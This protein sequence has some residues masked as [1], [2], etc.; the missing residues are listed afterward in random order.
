MSAP[1]L[2][3]PAEYHSTF[4][5]LHGKMLDYR[6]T[7]PFCYVTTGMCPVEVHTIGRIHY[8]LVEGV[9][10]A[11]AWADAIRAMS[12]DD[13]RASPQVEVRAYIRLH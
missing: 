8:M 6:H 9:E 11:V 7:C 5:S 12:S 4:L 10:E 13:G 1:A 3:P 2:S